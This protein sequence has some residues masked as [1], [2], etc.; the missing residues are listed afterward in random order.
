MRKNVPVYQILS[1]E[2][3]FHQDWVK[4]P[5]SWV[6]HIFS[7]LLPYRC[8]PLMYM[9]LCLYTKW[10][11]FVLWKFS[12][13]H[14]TIIPEC[15]SYSLKVSNIFNVYIFRLTLF[16]AQSFRSISPFFCRLCLYFLHACQ[17]IAHVV[18]IFMQ[19]FLFQMTFTWNFDM[20]M[21][22]VCS[23]VGFAKWIAKKFDQVAVLLQKC[24]FFSVAKL[25][26]LGKS[27]IFNLIEIV[28]CLVYPHSFRIKGKQPQLRMA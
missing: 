20:K 18:N 23:T 24:M 8:N 3:C 5:Q 27:C 15:K 11:Y 26:N 28:S 22:C 1:W 13:S 17:K 25:Y 19:Y 7:Y 6:L 12:L 16:K 10:G 14:S 9:V 21:E 2:Y 4:M